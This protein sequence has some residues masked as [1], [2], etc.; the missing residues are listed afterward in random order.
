MPNVVFAII[1]G[2]AGAIAGVSPDGKETGILATGIWLAW[3]VRI[4]LTTPRTRRRHQP[5]WRSERPY[6]EE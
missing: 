4:Y 2:L 1:V 5:G 3:G 6:R